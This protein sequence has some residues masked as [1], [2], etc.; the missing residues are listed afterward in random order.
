MPI[1]GLLMF[2]ISFE[3]LTASVIN[4]ISPKLNYNEDKSILNFSTE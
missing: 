3:K 1:G 4:S 2:F